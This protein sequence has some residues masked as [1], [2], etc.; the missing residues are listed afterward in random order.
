MARLSKPTWDR[1]WL[2]IRVALIWCAIA[3]SYLIGFA[4]SD[5]LRQNAFVAIAGLSASII[6]GYCG[7]ASWDDRN[8]LRAIGLRDNP[9]PPTIVVAEPPTSEN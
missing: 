4:P 7:F 2:V 9:Q 6:L 3:A 8:Y 5:G 1:R